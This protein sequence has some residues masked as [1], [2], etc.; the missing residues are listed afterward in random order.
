[1]TKSGPKIRMIL[2]YIAI[3]I[4]DKGEAVADKKKTEERMRKIGYMPP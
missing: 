1:M 3:A 2:M 4:R